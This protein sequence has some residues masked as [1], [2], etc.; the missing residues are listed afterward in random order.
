MSRDFALENVYGRLS[1]SSGISRFAY[2]PTK[3]S[4]SWTKSEVVGRSFASEFLIMP[5][6]NDIFALVLRA[7][8]VAS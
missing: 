1:V 2:E 7:N 8:F 3:Q 6:L 5:V 4:F